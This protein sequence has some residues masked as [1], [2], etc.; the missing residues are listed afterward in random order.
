MKSLDKINRK[1]NLLKHNYIIYNINKKRNYYC[2]VDY[3]QTLYYKPY[4]SEKLDL[5]KHGCFIVNERQ[6]VNIIKFRVLLFI[7]KNL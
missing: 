4:S 3:C 5:K 1:L 7:T 6:L 2:T